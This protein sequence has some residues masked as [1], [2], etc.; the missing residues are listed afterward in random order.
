MDEDSD[1]DDEFQIAESEQEPETSKPETDVKRPEEEPAH[2]IDL[3]CF[4][5]NL[6]RN[7]NENARNCWRISDGNNFKVRGKNFGQ[8]K[9]KIPAGK[10]LMDLVAV[11]WFKDSKRIDHVARRKG[12]A[13]QVR[14]TST[15]ILVT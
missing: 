2:N 12:C 8:E 14:Y 11:D 9:R 10:H 1:D 5:G 13:A 7:E 15:L 3:S 6:K 4:S